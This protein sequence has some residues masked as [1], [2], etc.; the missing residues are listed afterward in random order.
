MDPW[1]T[2][3]ALAHYALVSRG[4]HPDIPAHCTRLEVPLRRTLPQST[5]HAALALRLGARDHLAGICDARYVVASELKAARLS[6]FGAAVRP[7]V[8]R[9]KM[10][11]VDAWLAAPFEGERFTAVKAMGIPVVVCADYMEATPLARAEWMRLFGRLWGCGRRADSLFEHEAEAYETEARRYRAAADAA[12]RRPLVMVDR[13]EGESWFMPGGRSYVARVIAD[14]GGRYAWADDEHSGSLALDPER[15]WRR[16]ADADVWVIKYGAP[17]TLT[18]AS[19]AAQD[20][21]AVRFRAYR[22]RRVWGC[23]TLRRPYYEELPFA[24]SRLLHEW[25][26]V[27]CAAADSAHLVPTDTSSFFAPLH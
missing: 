19:L 22:R 1:D 6:D 2:L 24:P 26:E 27:L 20:P 9:M 3:A 11:G 17:L 23:N 15:V 4:A 18:Y 5:V 8:E 12:E 16:C 10:A 21:F 13:R 25:G 14:A 7:D